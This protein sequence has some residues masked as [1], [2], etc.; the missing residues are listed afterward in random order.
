M[1]SPKEDAETLAWLDDSLEY[2]RAAGQTKTEA[3]L[4]LVQI[5]V[6]EEME[7]SENYTSERLRNVGGSASSPRRVALPRGH[8][9]GEY[10]EGRG[11]ASDERT[12]SP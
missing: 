6:V 8:G 1:D 11:A 4:R 3:L 10:N 7:A 12:A 5:E 2:V 9:W